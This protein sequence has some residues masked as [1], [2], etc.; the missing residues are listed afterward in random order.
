M[1]IQESNILLKLINHYTMKNTPIK[2]IPKQ[3]EQILQ[4]G[5]TTHAPENS[6]FK[7]GTLLTV[8]HVSETPADGITYLCQSSPGFALWCSQ[9][10]LL[11]Y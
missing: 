6:N 8:I 2:T 4:Q 9:K 10:M 7:K 3:Q 11:G 1:Y 5:S